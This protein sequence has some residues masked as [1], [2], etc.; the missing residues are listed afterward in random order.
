MGKGERKRSGE[1]GRESGKRRERRTCIPPSR[2]TSKPTWLSSIPLV[3]QRQILSVS[4]VVYS[5]TGTLH[6][7]MKVDAPIIYYAY[8]V[9][10]V[11]IFYAY[12][13]L[14]LIKPSVPKLVYFCTVLG[15]IFYVHPFCY[16]NIY[17]Y[18]STLIT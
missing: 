6:S 11:F 8:T 1:T 17:T 15:I 3:V 10:K 5:Q 2:Q 14:I 18:T 9:L 4:E 16:I 7:E 13:V 12:T